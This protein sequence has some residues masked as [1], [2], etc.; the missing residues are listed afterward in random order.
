[1]KRFW[2]NLSAGLVLLTVA[3][4]NALRA[5]PREIKTVEDAAETVRAL[6]GIRLKGIPQGLLQD[7]QGVAVIPGVFRAGFVVGGRLGR[8]VVLSRQG[9]GTWGNPLFITLAGGGVGWQIGVQSTDLVLVFR[10]RSSVD[11]LFKGKDKLTLGGDISVAAGPVGREFSAG[12]DAQLRAEIYSYSRS[13]GLFAGLSLEGAG[14]LVDHKATRAFYGI[15]GG[16]AGDYGTQ[17]GAIAAA[18][19]RG[20]LAAL[21]TP[22]PPPIVLFP[23]QPPADQ[24]P[25]PPPPPPPPSQTW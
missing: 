9:G 11:R 6:A 15:P 2:M 24:P 20:Q 17:R 7:A 8:G 13:R 21:S 25:P 10:T 23:P 5:G 14:L 19:L 16:P 3:G 1:M 12:T 18:A 4:E 22:P